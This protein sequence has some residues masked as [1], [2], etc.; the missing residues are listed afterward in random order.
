MIDSDGGSVSDHDNNMSATAADSMNTTLN[1]DIIK[2]VD[3]EID[4]S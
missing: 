1:C 3:S 2:E 4:E